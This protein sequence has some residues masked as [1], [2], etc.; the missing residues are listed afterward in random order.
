MLRWK[1]KIESK[2]DFKKSQ[3]YIIQTADFYYSYI[4]EYIKSIEFNHILDIPPD[5][6]IE[7]LIL[8]MHVWL[9]FDRLKDFSEDKGTIDSFKNTLEGKFDEHNEEIL[10]KIH[11]GRKN[12]LILDTKD[13]LKNMR[14]LFDY[15][16]R[17]NLFTS[18]NPILKID[19]L[20]WSTVFLEKNDRYDDRIYLISSY[21]LETR[22]SLKRCSFEDIKQMK[23][24]FN[25]FIVP[26]NYKQLI[27]K[28]NPKLSPEEMK[29]AIE[30]SV[31]QNRKFRY[32]YKGKEGLI[33]KPDDVKLIAC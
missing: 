11:M 14:K 29:S 22:N 7:L 19:A 17:L 20:V 21:L 2:L 10:L 15:H 26:V 9:I 24:A 32:D 1:A 27:E 30:E 6:H 16:F 18:V 4:T 28:E 5:F 31:P 33:P 23:F 13:Y 25:P 8:N 12:D 3:S